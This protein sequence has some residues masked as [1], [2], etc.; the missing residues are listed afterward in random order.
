MLPIPQPKVLIALNLYRT[1]SFGDD[2]A[3]WGMT[4]TL[5]L[6]IIIKYNDTEQHWFLGFS[7]SSEC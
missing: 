5:R 4:I 2:A 7:P 3:I 6:L 1:A